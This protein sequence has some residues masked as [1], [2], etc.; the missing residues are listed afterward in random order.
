MLV[1]DREESN[2]SKPAHTTVAARAAS[3]ISRLTT[4]AV[5]P[6]AMYTLAGG[7][8]LCSVRSVE[9]VSMLVVPADSGIGKVSLIIFSAAEAELRPNFVRLWT[10]SIA[11]MDG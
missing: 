8:P 5:R 2:W 1:E 10:R 9:H 4:D 7:P 11:R 6:Q 3:S